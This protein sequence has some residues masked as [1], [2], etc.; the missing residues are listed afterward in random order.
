[1]PRSI[2]TDD[3]NIAEG[4]G[5][6]PINIFNQLNITDLA[7]LQVRSSIV[8]RNKVS[9]FSFISILSCIYLGGFS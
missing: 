6:S 7:D 5:I 4:S 8:A 1:M 9:G 3:L 2:I